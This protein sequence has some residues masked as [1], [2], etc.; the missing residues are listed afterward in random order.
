M[1]LIADCQE[2]AKRVI[3]KLNVMTATSNVRILMEANNLSL[4]L[5]RF[6][7]TLSAVMAGNE[8]GRKI[9]AQ[10]EKVTR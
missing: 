5:K 4:A 10:L 1:N 3:P 7:L 8:E 9:L 2:V 6:E